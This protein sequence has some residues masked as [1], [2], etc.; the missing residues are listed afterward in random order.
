MSMIDSVRRL[1]APDVP[2][3]VMIATTNDRHPDNF[4]WYSVNIFNKAWLDTV[5]FFSNL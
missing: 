3:V 5:I 1:S 4:F 2:K